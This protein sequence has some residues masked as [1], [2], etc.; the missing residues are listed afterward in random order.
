[1]KHLRRKPEGVDD[2]MYIVG[3]GPN[4]LRQPVSLV[5]DGQM[6]KEYPHSGS[7]G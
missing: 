4:L 2:V 3:S 7:N 1:M 6:R 5:R